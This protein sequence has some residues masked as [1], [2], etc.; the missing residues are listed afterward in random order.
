MEQYITYHKIIDLLENYQV[1]SPR[2]NSFGYGVVEDFGQNTSGVTTIYPMM[3]VVP[4]SILYDENVTTY[5]LSILFADRLN[6]DVSNQVDAITDMSLECR[7]FISTIK[8]GYLSDYMEITLPG[9]AIPFKERFNDNV[10]GVALNANI[11]VY[12]DINACLYYS[13]I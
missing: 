11:V 13:G 3:F 2:L 5:Q 4:Q 1:S 6:D 10:A 9:D 12:E 7:Q 8:R